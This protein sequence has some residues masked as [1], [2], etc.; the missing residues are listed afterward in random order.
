MSSFEAV[1]ESHIKRWVTRRQLREQVQREH[2]RAQDPIVL[3]PPLTLSHADG[4]G[5]HEIAAAV[6]Q[7]AGLQLLDREIIEAISQSIRVQSQIIELLDE[8]RQNMVT[9]LVDQLF[10]RRV[11]DDMSYAHAL[12]RV[13]RS[14]SLLEPSLFIGRGA[15]HILRETNG[16][17]VR[18]VAALEGRVRRIVEREEHPVED[19]ENRV[20]QQ[21]LQRR[22]FIKSHFNRDIDDPLAY[23]VVLN[24]SRIALAEATEIIVDLYRSRSPQTEKKLL[25][26]RS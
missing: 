1:V 18:I 3:P 10:S 25:S 2:D 23:H 15:C 20:K 8:G 9:S 13:V 17:H 6:C 5:G 22:R 12:A 19:A 14:I 26:E 7:R 21:D 4:S 16:F 11:I 24:T